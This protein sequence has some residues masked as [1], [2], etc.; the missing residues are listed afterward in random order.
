MCCY[1]CSPTRLHRIVVLVGDDS[2]NVFFYVIPDGCPDV[3]PEVFSDV[4][5]DD[6]N[7]YLNI[8]LDVLCHIR[9]EKYFFLIGAFT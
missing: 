5:L 7:I 9:A 2:P 6:F 4:S 3:P 1:V 8:L